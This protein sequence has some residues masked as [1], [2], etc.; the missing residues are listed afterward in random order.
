MVNVAI[1]TPVTQIPYARCRKRVV[2]RSQTTET[3]YKCALWG[4]P[5]RSAEYDGGQQQAQ[6]PALG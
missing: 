1:S 4:L 3:P 6:H 2:E 5:D